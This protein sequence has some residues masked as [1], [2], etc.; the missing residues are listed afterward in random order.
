MTSLY[1]LAN[2]YRVVANTIED[3]DLPAESIRDTL[4]G[5]AGDLEAK[6]ANVAMVVRNLETTIS[7]IAEAEE[8]MQLRREALEN[9]VGSIKEYIKENM[10]T[11]GINVISCPYFVLKIQNNPPSIVIDNLDA[12]PVEYIN[13]PKLLPQ[14]PNKRLMLEVMKD[15]KDIPGARLIQNKRLV[16]K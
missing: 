1:V 9:R 14:S 2:E 13:P 6:A 12:V 16:I 15:G 5:L 11:S 8:Q 7:A 4:E 10:I 3:M